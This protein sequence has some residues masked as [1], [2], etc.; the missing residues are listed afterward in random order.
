MSDPH[1]SN[2]YPRCL[3]TGDIIVKIG[4]THQAT[5]EILAHAKYLKH[6]ESLTEIKENLLEAAIGKNHIDSATH[7][8]VVKTLCACFGGVMAVLLVVIGF[9]LTGEKLGIIGA[10]HR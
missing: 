2:G 10:L 5:R 3:M 7:R 6:L 4:E 1:L 9:L 8:L